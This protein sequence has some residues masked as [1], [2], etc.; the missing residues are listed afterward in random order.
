MGYAS[1]LFMAVEQTLDNMPLFM[2]C[3]RRYC[4]PREWQRHPNLWSRVAESAEGERET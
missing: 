3:F 2:S 4:T 1:M